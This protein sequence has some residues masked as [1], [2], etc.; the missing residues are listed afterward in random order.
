MKRAISAS[1]VSLS[2]LLVVGC[3]G[4]D[5]PLAPATRTALSADECRFEPGEDVCARTFDLPP[6]EHEAFVSAAQAIATVAGDAR[7]LAL[8]V[9]NACEGIVAELG[10]SPSTETELVDAV[11]DACGRATTL[12]APVAHLEWTASP[13]ASE[14][15]VTEQ[16]PACLRAEDGSQLRRTACAGW[17]IEFPTLDGATPE[18]V[19]AAGALKQYG[20]ILLLSKAQVDR[21]VE[22]MALVGH[23]ID[24]ASRACASTFS[25][26]LGT[27]SSETDAA[28]TAVGALFDAIDS[29]SCAHHGQCPPFPPVE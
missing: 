11:K 6:Q 27:A 23:H 8:S 9:R 3:A 15:C 7:D 4:E 28:V 29:R 16:S 2:F 22:S 17:A 26:M 14:T 10:G 20:G 1:S 21:V 18:A 24:V 25:P 19:K 12:L 13:P 5:V